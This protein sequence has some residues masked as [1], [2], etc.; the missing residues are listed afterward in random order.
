MTTITEKPDVV[1]YPQ[2]AD[3]TGVSEMAVRKWTERYE[4]FPEPDGY[5]SRVQSGPG[6]TPYWLW[7]SIADFLD[8]H[9]NLGRVH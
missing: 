4:D 1:G 2:I 3:R 9:P 6:S 8:R 5:L 7:D